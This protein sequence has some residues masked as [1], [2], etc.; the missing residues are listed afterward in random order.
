MA[1]PDAVGEALAQRPG[2]RLHAGGH[3][4]FGVAGRLAPPLAEALDLLQRKVVA[5][6]VKQ[7]V[8]Q[9]R[10]VAGGEDKAIPIGPL[11]IGGIELRWRVHK[12]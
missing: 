2:R 12:T 9:R 1:M 5:G 3:A 4:V 7:G 8:E 6:Q 10:A 11:R